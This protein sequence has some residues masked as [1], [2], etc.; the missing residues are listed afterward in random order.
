M[1]QEKQNEAVRRQ[2]ALQ[3]QQ[4][5]EETEEEEGEEDHKEAEAGMHQSP[6][7]ELSTPVTHSLM[8]FSVPFS[9]KALPCYFSKA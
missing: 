6:A 8:H 2:Q 3:E 9:E 4:Q 1:L 5:E 7:R